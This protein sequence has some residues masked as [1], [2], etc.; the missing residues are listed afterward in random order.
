MMLCLQYI[1]KLIALY[2]D[3]VSLLTHILVGAENLALHKPSIQSSDYRSLYPASKAVDGI[4]YGSLEFS[5]T[6]ESQTDKQWWTVD[7]G[8]VKSVR[9]IELYNK[10]DSG[11]MNC[12]IN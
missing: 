7:F 11:G 12:C 6:K 9:V 10:F 1:E 4:F 8:S 2:N 3:N 5:H